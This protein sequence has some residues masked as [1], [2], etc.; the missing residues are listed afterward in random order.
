MSYGADVARARRLMPLV[1]EG[2]AA[3]LTEAASGLRSRIGDGHHPG[4]YGNAANRLHRGENEAIEYRW[5][6]NQRERLPALAAKYE[7]A[8]E[9]LEWKLSS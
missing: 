7:D 1:E 4:R 5:A 2:F 3:S 6:E 8:W 9:L